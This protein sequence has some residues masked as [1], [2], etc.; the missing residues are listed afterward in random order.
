MCEEYG[1]T[2]SYKFKT[3]YFMS[4]KYSNDF[5]MRV[6][7]KNDELLNAI[8]RAFDED[9]S[10]IG[11]D[12]ISTQFLDRLSQ[13][14]IRCAEPK[15]DAWHIDT[16]VKKG[17][18]LAFRIGKKETMT[19]GSMHFV[20]KDNLWPRSFT[21][22]DP[23]RIVP[24]ASTVR[25]GAYLGKNVTL[26]P[27][28]YVN[29]GAYVDDD[30][31]IDSHALVGSCA[32]IG[33]RCHISAGSQIGGVL[34]PI[35]ASPVIIEDNCMI[36]GNTG[37]YEGTRIQSGAIIGAGV[38]LTKSVKVYDLVHEK[39]IMAQNDDDVVIIP[40]N[41]VV[42]PGARTLNLP[43]AQ[44]HGLSVA[45]PMIVK[46]RDDLTDTKIRLESLLR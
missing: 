12:E 26:M 15:N 7:M 36:G 5:S 23:V 35:G 4:P 46:Y 25:R 6:V 34:E 32:Q 3:N 42:V 21:D 40:K 39:I 16:R 9:M 45:A 22:K 33:K 31:M 30:T 2:R 37:I 13:G 27:P 24:Y 17:I 8:A 1:Y 44:A 28:S 43:F 14:I 29:I 10:D 38:I 18:L 11:I 19:V 20:D 41:A